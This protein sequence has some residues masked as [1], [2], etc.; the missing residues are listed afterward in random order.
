MN[1]LLMADTESIECAFQGGGQRIKS[2]AATWQTIQPLLPKI[3]ITRVASVTGLDRIGI[4]VMTAIRPNSRSLAISMGKGVDVMSARVSAAMESIENYYAER[5][6]KPLRYASYNELRQQCVV[7]DVDRLPYTTGSPFHADLPILW[8]EAQQW[9]SQQTVWVPYEL[10]HTDYTTRQLPGEDSFLASSNGL[11]SGNHPVEA[12]L[13]AVYEVI[14]RDAIALWRQSSGAEFLQSRLDLST[15]NH[16]IAQDLIERIQQAGLALG[17]WNITSDVG[18][19]VFIC[20]MMDHT[21][22]HVISNGMGCHA[23]RAIALIRALTEA[24]QTRMNAI[25]GAREDIPHNEYNNNTE[26]DQRMRLLL[27]TATG[28]QNYTTINHWPEL[29]LQE[30]LQLLAERLQDIDCGQILYL[31]LT[32]AVQNIAVMRVI[33]PGLEGFYEHPAY[34]PGD[35]AR[36]I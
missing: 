20:V 17:V 16:P 24:V 7:V 22:S 32:D 31:N 9:I 18:L 28:S 30:T 19:P 6:N 2:P 11:A 26:R 23:N 21:G 35:R 5:I 8:I 27:N 10:V 36:T 4:P 13:H 15:V 34:H 14:E 29:S 3:G 33:V 12:Y 25:V 1:P